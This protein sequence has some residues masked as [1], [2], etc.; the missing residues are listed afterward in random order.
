MP[1]RKVGKNR[2]RRRGKIYTRKQI[3]AI[4]FAKLRRRKRK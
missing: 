3:I 1:Y 4:H 2:Y